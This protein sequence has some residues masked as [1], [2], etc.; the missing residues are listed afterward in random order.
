[1]NEICSIKI[2]NFELMQE[3]YQIISTTLVVNGYFMF[4]IEKCKINRICSFYLTSSRLNNLLLRKGIL[5][6]FL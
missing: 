4:I 3:T 1:M 6:V 2:S 5:I